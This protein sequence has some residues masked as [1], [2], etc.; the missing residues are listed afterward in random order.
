M[1]LIILTGYP[2]SGLS[3][4]AKQL[5]H[6]LEQTQT[7]LFDALDNETTDGQAKPKQ[8]R[9][10]FHIVPSHDPGHPR[11]VYD[12]ART[13]KEA[14]AVA[15]AR[16]KRALAKD[17]FVILDGMNYIKG[18][19]Y[20]LWCEAKAVGTTCC[21]VHVGTPIDKC[22]A[23]N[24]SRLN[25]QQRQVNLPDASSNTDDLAEP[26]TEDPYPS[27]LHQNLIFR[28]E[29]PSTHSRWDKPLFTVPWTDAR[30]PIE[31]IWTATTGIE[32]EKNIPPDSTPINP[33]ASLLHTDPN[34]PSPPSTAQQ[35]T[36]SIAYTIRTTATTNANG[37]NRLGRPRIKPH[38][39]TVLPTQTD[40]SALYTYEK[41]TSAIIT[42]IR[43]YT[44]SNPSVEAALARSAQIGGVKRADEEG[45][46]I[47]VPDSSIAV[48]IPAHIVRSAPTD[49]LAGAGGL[50][51]LPRLQR[52]RRQWISQNRTYIG[53]THNQVK[54]A[55]GSDQVGDAFVRFLNFE[56]AG[57]TTE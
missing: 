31:E 36:A 7:Q 6:L 52:L 32:I 15:Y 35:D 40:S 8:K 34:T 20:Q 16:V 24:N 9:F 41:K 11:T 38:Q 13:E 26:D 29:E 21:V 28:Y 42:A 23:I 44:S 49:D 46:S 12:N 47:T 39:A 56:F 50:L 18:Y 14:R 5:A 1:P 43:N 53:M 57:D 48:F 51:T 37:S 19:R 45:I 3:Y 22:V 30:P 17:A 2:S 33:L 25:R 4:R 55:L 10:T 27:D 54:G